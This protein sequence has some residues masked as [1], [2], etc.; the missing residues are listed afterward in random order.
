ME[1]IQ[2]TTI[3]KTLLMLSE[4]S[5]QSERALDPPVSER[6]KVIPRRATVSMSL[7][8]RSLINC[9]TYRGN[10]LASVT[11]RN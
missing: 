11:H 7:G 2:V 4:R 6:E 10:A 9:E 1:A 8:E 3:M 5:H